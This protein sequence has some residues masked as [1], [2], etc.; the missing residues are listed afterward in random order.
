MPVATDIPDQTATA[1]C[2]PSRRELLAE[3]AVFLALIVPSMVLSFFVQSGRNISF[4]FLAVST[5]FRDLALLAL[6]LFFVW[7][8]REPL[9]GLGLTT[10]DLDRNL[11]L[12]YLIQRLRTATRSTTAAVV[13]SAVI[14]ALGHGYEGSLGMATVGLMGLVFSLIY[15]W[16]QSLVAPMVLHFIQNFIAI[17]LA[18]H[19]R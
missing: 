6:V 17:I 12:G 13:L 11:F 4:V 3:A 10:R 8:N 19:W 1:P 7:R 16:K 5:I 14:F 9:R 2:R 18:P 15:L